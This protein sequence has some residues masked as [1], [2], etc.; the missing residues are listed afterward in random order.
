MKLAHRIGQF[1]WRALGY[2]QVYGAGA[3]WMDTAGNAAGVAVTE[4]AALSC[5]AVFAAV[6]AISEDIAKLPLIVYRRI[7]RNKERA[8]DHP[9]YRLL[10]DEPNEEMTAFAFRQAM[11]AAALL[12]GRG[13]AEIERNGRGEPVAL[14]PIHPDRVRLDR[15]PG[16]Q[17]LHVVVDSRV[18]LPMRDVLYLPG[19]SLDGV[20]GEMV[21][22]IGRQSIGLTLAVE[23]FGASFFANGARPGGFLKHP[24]KLSDKARQNLQESWNADNAGPAKAHKLQILEEG[25]E[26]TQ[27]STPPEEAQ[28]LESRQFGIE[29]VARWFRIPPHK[30]QQLLRATFSNIEHQ[31]IEY[32]T[33]TLMPW[34]VRWEQE[35]DRKVLEPGLHAEHLA[36]ALLRGD[37]LSRSQA[38]AQQF[39]NGALTINEW[40]AIEN[41]N[42]LPDDLGD[43]HYVPLNL[44]EVGE[45][46]E[47]DEPEPVEPEDDPATEP[48]AEA[49]DA[50]NQALEDA[51]ARCRARLEKSKRPAIEH[52][53]ILR[54]MLAPAVKML[55]ALGQTDRTAEDHAKEILSEA[56]YGTT[57]HTKAD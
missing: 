28:F 48:N 52:L 54:D 56:C 23:K 7:G 43:A 22:R 8:E 37:T 19:F 40:R 16:S 12:W 26:Y 9:V 25:M 49:I 32:V 45:D 33:D 3:A 5:S 55:A 29:E 10:H 39:N 6:R 51:R 15:E 41:R 46:P 44:A 38:L 36:D 14:W 18:K 13:I 30:V 2:P 35:L 11:T 1:L 34:F 47:E 24:A 50:A 31:S 27:A 57:Q 53:P 17:R 4:T 20:I 42:P 21:S